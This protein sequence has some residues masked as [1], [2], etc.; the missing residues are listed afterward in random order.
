MGNWIETARGTVYPWHCDHMGHMNVMWY[1]GRFDEA[2]WQLFA[3]LG[4]D[5]GYLSERRRGMAAVDQH[6]QYLRE[7]HAGDVLAIRSGVLE[8]REKSLR[9]V[10]EMTVG[11][12]GA[13]A[14][15]SVLVGVQIDTAN[16]RAAALAPAIASAAREHLVQ[17]P[18][19]RGSA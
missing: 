16:R 15:T 3:A 2:T 10:H 19:D 8:V 7:L 11:S 17:W 6:L 13:V 14:A 4:M 12:G 18:V 1:V 5:R 9:F